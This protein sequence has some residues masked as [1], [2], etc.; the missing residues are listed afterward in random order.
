MFNRPKP[1]YSVQSRSSSTKVFRTVE[2]HRLLA[3]EKRQNHIKPY[4]G[5]L[6]LNPSN[7]ESLCHQLILTVAAYL[8]ELPATRNSYFTNRGGFLEHALSRTESALTLARDYFI[9]DSGQKANDLTP[10]QQL[11]MYA[12]FSAAMLK[13]IG[14]L[15]TDFIIEV[16]EPPQNRLKTYQPLDKPLNQ[17][18]N[19][20]D[21]NFDIPFP[22]SFKKR[23][24]V[25]LAHQ[26]MP[27]QGLVW[28]NSNKDVLATWLALLEEDERA[29]GTLGLIID[30]ADA[31]AISRYF[32][33]RLIAQYGEGRDNKRI[34]S[35]TFIGPDRQTETELKEGD[36]PPA[37]VEFIK[38]LN[39]QLAG[40]KI[41]INQA[42]LFMVPGGLLMNPDIFK[43]FIRESP[44]FKNWQQVQKS[45]LQMQ[46][47][48]I[49]ADGASGQRFTQI[50]NKKIHTGIVFSALGVVLPQEV[51][52]ANMSN[53]VIKSV[54]AS[55]LIANKQIAANFKAMTSSAPP[56]QAISARGLLVNQAAQSHARNEFS[57]TNK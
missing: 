34:R 10:E 3:T 14:K 19:Y 56:P 1:N 43:L 33:E 30:R 52:V 25:L 27:T 12:L 6:N 16:Y 26:L 20:Y 8:Q 36:L 28:L 32:N 57:Q 22:D 46:L 35:G 21:Y 40:G 31:L 45:L 4:L 5:L 53:G 51:R 23:A 9:D 54:P 39:R 29:A 17:A 7:Y 47:H 38:W 55:E 15:I 41:A 42:P 49:G 24:T 50:D 44:M 37:G 13:G 48:Q 18:A 2:P 11:W